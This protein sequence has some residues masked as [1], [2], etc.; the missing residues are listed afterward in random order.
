MHAYT[1]TFYCVCLSTVNVC[2]TRSRATVYNYNGLLISKQIC[3]H[4]ISLLYM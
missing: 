2:D 1:D 4:I 3:R